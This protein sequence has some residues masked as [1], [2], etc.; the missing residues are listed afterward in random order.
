[1]S[2]NTSIT[3]GDHFDHFISE[4]ISE[5]R[6][7]SASDLVRAGLRML[8]AKEVKRR[9]LRLALSEGEKSGKADYSLISLIEELDN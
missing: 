3:L 7:G 9:A 8:E 5:G 2:K 1:M 4:Q 6:Y